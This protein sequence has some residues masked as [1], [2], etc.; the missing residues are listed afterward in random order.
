MTRTFL[1]LHNLMTRT[2]LPLN[3]LMKRTFQTNKNVENLQ[4]AVGGSDEEVRIYNLNDPNPCLVLT[5]AWGGLDLC[6]LH[7]THLFTASHIYPYVKMW[8]LGP[9][10]CP[11]TPTL[12]QNFSVAP[13]WSVDPEKNGIICSVDNS[14]K[15]LQ[16]CEIKAKN[17]TLAP[18]DAEIKL[19]DVF[20]ETNILIL[21][22]DDIFIDFF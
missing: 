7:G 16:I 17:V 11:E 22:S 14:Q 21:T 4:L 6:V 18:F 9:T 1:Q 5:G 2:F 15:F 20:D 10:W 13:S 8:N 12:I 3:N 19:I